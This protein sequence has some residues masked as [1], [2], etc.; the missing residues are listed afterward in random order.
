MSKQLLTGLTLAIAGYG[1]YRFLNK[2]EAVNTNIE[3]TDQPKYHITLAQTPDANGSF[4]NDTTGAM[5][6]SVVHTINSLALRKM[7]V[8]VGDVIRVYRVDKQQNWVDGEQV[9][10]DRWMIDKI[11]V[12]TE[13]FGNRLIHVSKPL[14]G[15]HDNQ[16]APHTRISFDNHTTPQTYYN[17]TINHI[18]VQH[19]GYVID[20]GLVR[21]IRQ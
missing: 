4:A 20:M 6:G 12:V 16:I 8:A 19:I 5:V 2:E 17:G 21:I 7:P 1:V 18:K 13:L 14:W 3:F 11:V 15:G 9:V 10:T